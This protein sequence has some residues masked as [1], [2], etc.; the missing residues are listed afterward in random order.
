METICPRASPYNARRRRPMQGFKWYRPGLPVFVSRGPQPRQ[1]DC[2][3]VSKLAFS[4][5]F[6]YLQTQCTLQDK[7]KYG[8]IYLHMCSSAVPKGQLWQL[9]GC[10]SPCRWGDAPITR[11][12]WYH[13]IMDSSLGQLQGLQFAQELSGLA[14][15]LSPS[16][17]PKTFYRSKVCLLTRFYFSKY[18]VSTFSLAVLGKQWEATQEGKLPL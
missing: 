15:S 11:S 10:C 2:K 16:L 13:S 5:S 4:F 1:G 8:R 7:H 9:H 6:G 14:P 18:I 17:S 12:L 3:H